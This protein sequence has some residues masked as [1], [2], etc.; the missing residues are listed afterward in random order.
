VV[1]R[2][3]VGD[4]QDEIQL[5]VGTDEC[6][7][8]VGPLLGPSVEQPS[9]ESHALG[10]AVRE[11]AL[12]TSMLAPSIFR[13][14]PSAIWLR[15]EF[16]THRNKMRFIQLSSSHSRKGLTGPLHRRAAFVPALAGVHDFYD[17]EHDRNLD[18]NAD[19]GGKRRP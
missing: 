5:Q 16:A 4:Q 13:A 12:V 14:R 15:A 18:Q 11:P 19:D 8:A 17:R 3:A 9:I 1:Q 7:V 6:R 10:K 2:F